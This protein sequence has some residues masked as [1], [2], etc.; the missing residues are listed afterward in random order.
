MSVASTTSVNGPVEG[1]GG[2]EG[3]LPHATVSTIAAAPIVA[4][5]RRT[6]VRGIAPPR[7]IGRAPGT[8]PGAPRSWGPVAHAARAPSR[9]IGRAPGTPP[10]APRSWG[11]VA[12]RRSRA[13][14]RR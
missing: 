5:P 9:L 4:A 1:G 10:G 14:T 8:P 3:F 12:P 6:I 11:P 7:L 2:G 13:V